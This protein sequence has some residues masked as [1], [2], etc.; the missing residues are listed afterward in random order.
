[1]S[2]DRLA[3]CIYYISFGECEKGKMA[4]MKRICKTCKHY[5][6]RKGFKAVDKRREERYKY[7]E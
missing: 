3:P 5:Q 1:M 2:K 7:Y 6:P 4:N